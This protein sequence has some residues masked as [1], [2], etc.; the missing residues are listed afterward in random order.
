MWALRPRQQGEGVALRTLLLAL[1]SFCSFWRCG[2]SQLSKCFGPNKDAVPIGDAQP[3]TGG[4][5]LDVRKTTLDEY[6]VYA[7]G[8]VP[9]VNILIESSELGSWSPLNASSIAN[10]I[11][12]SLCSGSVTN[13][14]PIM[15]MEFGLV[16]RTA[17]TSCIVFTLTVVRNNDTWFA[18]ITSDS[19]QS[20]N[21]SEIV[22][23]GPPPT[24]ND[25]DL[26]VASEDIA[27]Y[28][29]RP[30]FR[31]TGVLNITCFDDNEWENTTQECRDID[32]CTE[33]AFITCHTC[34]NTRGSYMCSCNNYYSL[35][36]GRCFRSCARP[37]HHVSSEFTPANGPFLVNIELTFQCHDG[38][39][40]EGEKVLQCL[41]KTN[42]TGW[43]SASPKCIK[44]EEVS[45]GGLSSTQIAI[46]AICSLAGVA[47]ITTVTIIAV[48]SHRRSMY[49]TMAKQRSRTSMQSQST[50]MV[51]SVSSTSTSP[52]ASLLPGSG[53]PLDNRRRTKR[54]SR[55]ERRSR[56][57]SSDSLARAQ[58][59]DFHITP[60]S[61]D[62]SFQQGITEVAE[63]G[64]DGG[65]DMELELLRAAVQRDGSRN[66]KISTT[67]QD[68][69]LLGP[70]TAPSSD[71]AAIG[72]R[73][74]V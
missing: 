39:R 37:E 25:A 73:G 59:N 18:N 67:S 45:T 29:C 1:A 20:Q 71:Y 2:N 13:A 24:L 40:L 54:N 65:D 51:R 15:D 14:V 8:Q 26:L 58:E 35:I 53:D 32:E 5:S 64:F 56:K 63:E 50:R 60:A 16:F 69:D 27:A 41:D 6:E 43:S 49:K 70:G 21:G 33:D 7:K 46:I 55:V 74:V 30:G 31:E 34:V 3:G 28:Q 66:A 47:L 36:R 4:Y 57:Y 23:C 38:Y 17:S 22:G 52:E 62:I 48:I 72:P 19:C 12:Q 42:T 11:D 68:S 10:S 44:I 61:G 9:F